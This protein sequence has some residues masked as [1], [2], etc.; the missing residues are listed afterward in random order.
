MNGKKPTKLLKEEKRKGY[1][2]RKLKMWKD[3]HGVWNTT[4][5]LADWYG[6]SKKTM[7]FRINKYG[8]YDPNV[9]QGHVGSGYTLD[10][11]TYSEC[12]LNNTTNTTSGND[13]WKNLKG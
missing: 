9:L 12:Q 11:R 10:G 3:E 6:V 7:A 4:Q 5:D 13:E 2:G 8:P 1:F